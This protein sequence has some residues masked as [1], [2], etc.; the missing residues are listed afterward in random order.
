VSA[1]TPRER[2]LDEIVQG[3][4]LTYGEIMRRTCGNGTSG[5]YVDV[6]AAIA[7]ALTRAE[8]MAVALE[9][10]R[11]SHLVVE[12]D[13]WYSC[14]ESGECCDAARRGCTCGADASNAKIDAALA[15]WTNRLTSVQAGE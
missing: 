1:Q 8:A 13:C 4:Q 2:A 6:T 15:A 14:P 9:G 10:L 7:A 3:Y 11:R 12:G 5:L